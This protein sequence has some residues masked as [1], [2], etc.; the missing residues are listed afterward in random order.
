M[1]FLALSIL[2]A[3]LPAQDSANALPLLRDALDFQPVLSLD[4]DPKEVLLFLQNGQVGRLAPSS[5]I[6][7]EIKKKLNS[8]FQMEVRL[9]SKDR[10]IETKAHPPSPVQETEI[11]HDPPS[12]SPD[13]E[14]PS[15]LTPAEAK[16]VFWSMNPN[17]RR[18]SQCFN[19][20]HVWTYETLKFRKIRLMK[21]FMFFTAKYIREYH[22]RWWFHVSP[23]AYVN[24]QSLIHESI[25]DYTFMDGPVDPKGWSDRFI[26]ARTP[27]PT[28]EKYSDYSNHQYEHHCYFMKVPMYFWQPRHLE[29][30]ESGGPIPDQF[31]EDEVRAAY[32]QGFFGGP[33]AESMITHVFVNSRSA[34]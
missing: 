24:D 8:R 22:Y 19:R 29:A 31:I 10:V 2:F 3:P 17:Y 28:V 18:R 26:A 6:Y 15:I 1:V 9:D 20:A 33:A 11:L 30:R 7:A 21:V 4:E 16:E 32:T 12:A 13:L 27:C 5:A 23:F 34:K 14:P 25:L